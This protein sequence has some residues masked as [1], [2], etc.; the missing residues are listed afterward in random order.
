VRRTAAANVKTG[1]S[2]VGILGI[3]AAEYELGR[4]MSSNKRWTLEKREQEL[5]RALISDASQQG[6]IRAA[7]HVREARLAVLK[8]TE[9]E[10]VPAESRPA[11]AHA[12]FPDEW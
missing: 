12:P 1:V 11:S 2:I 8:K 9:S 10:T 6:I 7:E 3:I 5:R 4:T